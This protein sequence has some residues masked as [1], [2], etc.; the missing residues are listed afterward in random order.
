M[1][2]AAALLLIFV[3]SLAVIMVIAALT[4]QRPPTMEE[5][6]SVV[7]KQMADLGM[8]MDTALVPAAT[9]ATFA[10]RAFGESVGR[11]RPMKDEPWPTF[12]E[13]AEQ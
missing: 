8:A 12:G 7:A 3:V 4:H 2:D 10:L 13:G 11:S 5:R 6:M 9:E 1:S